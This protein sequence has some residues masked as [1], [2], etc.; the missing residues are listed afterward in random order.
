L[1]GGAAATVTFATL[2][3]AFVFNRWFLTRGAEE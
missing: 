2:G 1:G 3:P